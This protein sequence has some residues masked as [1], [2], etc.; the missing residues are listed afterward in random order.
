[1]E[2]DPRLP[3]G[4]PSRT[5]SGEWLCRQNIAHYR[6]QLLRER[7]ETRRATLEKLMV[8]EEEKLRI[9][10]LGPLRRPAPGG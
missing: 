9:F 5:V 6:A 10:N 2:E 1:M 7:S 8:E 3:L 4:S